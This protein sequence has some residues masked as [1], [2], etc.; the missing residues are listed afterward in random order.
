MRY[1]VNL[2]ASLYI[3]NDIQRLLRL[4]NIAVYAGSDRR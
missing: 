2:P 3:E 4:K 1:D